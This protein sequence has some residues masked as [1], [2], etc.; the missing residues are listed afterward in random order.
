MKRAFQRTTNIDLTGD[1]HND[2]NKDVR[3]SEQAIKIED[4]EF[5]D[6]QEGGSAFQHTLHQMYIQPRSQATDIN[7]YVNKI[8]KRLKHY[9]TGQLVQHHGVKFNLSVEVDYDSNKDAEGIVKGYWTTRNRVVHS[10]DEIDEIMEELKIELTSRNENFI[11]ERSGLVINSINR[12]T[13]R[14]SEFQSLVASSFIQLPTYLEKKK[15]IINVQN[16]DQRCFGYAIL[17]ALYPPDINPHRRWQYDQY[18]IPHHLDQLP[19]PIAPHQVEAIEA[20]LNKFPENNFTINIFTFYDDNGRL[21]AP[22]YLSKNQNRERVIDLLYFEGKASG[23]T[24]STYHYAWI[25]SFSRFMSDITKHRD[26]KFWCRRCLGHFHCATSL[27]KHQEWCRGDNLPHPIVSMPSPFIDKYGVEH[28]PAVFFKNEKYQQ[29]SP[30]VIVADFE[31]ITKKLL[32]PRGR[33]HT[34]KT[35]QHVPFSAGLYMIADDL[36]NN[37]PDLPSLHNR[38]YEFY[39]G[40]DCVNWFLERLLAI[41]QDCLKVLFDPRRLVMTPHDQLEFDKST[42]CHICKGRLAQPPANRRGSADPF[43]NKDDEDEE[44]DI[45]DG[46]SQTRL[47]REP[48]RKVRDHDHITGRFRGAAHSSCNLRM[49]TIYKIPVFLHNFRGYDSHLIVA[50]LTNF[51]AEKIRIIGQTLEKYLTLQWGDH[52][53]FKDSYQFMATS[54][55]MLTTNLLKAGR[56]KFF[57]LLHKFQGTPTE[58]IDLL[59][60]KGVFPYDY[61]D[62]KE[63]FDERQLPTREQFYNSLRQTECSEQDYQHAQNVWRKFNCQTFKDYEELYLKTGIYEVT[64]V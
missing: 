63:K 55:E 44:D 29:K 35:Q 6:E 16:D 41:K 57:H 27:Q 21:R 14:F 13:L 36:T 64:S 60:R 38:A 8:A 1:E 31:A 53:V 26:V 7:D 9:I 15:A 30:F 19:Y 25:K 54:L 48:E 49:R 59:L 28:P 3:R 11:R 2:F 42:D 56:D 61:F 24:E 32:L 5:F 34:I 46:G 47:V 40:R 18:F 22:L 52:I 37:L 58:N 10:V 33:T 50:G 12:A 62:S 4:N 23:N 51:P 20:Q 43:D 45:D 39:S 17:S